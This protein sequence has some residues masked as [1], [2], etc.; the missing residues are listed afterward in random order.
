MLFPSASPYRCSP[1]ERGRRWPALPIGWP[2][3][4]RRGSPARYVDHGVADLDD[5]TARARGALVDL[6][7]AQQVGV[8]EK[9]PQEPTQL[10]HR[11]WGA[12]ETTDDRAPAKRLRVEAA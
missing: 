9:I 7:L 2:G 8:I 12:V 5:A 4:S 10:P 3:R 6:V 11:L 1:G